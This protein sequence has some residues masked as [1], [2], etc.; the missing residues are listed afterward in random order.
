VIA[1]AGDETGIGCWTGD[2]PPRVSALVANRRRIVASDA[3]A[4]SALAAANEGSDLLVHTRWH[5]LL[6]R[7]ALTRRFYRTFEQ[8]VAALAASL[9]HVPKA[10]AAELALLTA[11]RLLFLCFSRPASTNACRTAEAFMVGCCCRCSSGR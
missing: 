2:R 3:E 9:I 8:R 10:E 7:E 11:S 1:T 6:G 5:E 4:L